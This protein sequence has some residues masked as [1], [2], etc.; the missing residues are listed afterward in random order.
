MSAISIL[1]SGPQPKEGASSPVDTSA[2]STLRLD[3]KVL[4][5]LG[6]DPWL[7]YWIETRAGT[8]SPWRTLHYGAFD[9]ALGTWTGDFTQRVIVTPDNETRI[10][11]SGDTRFVFPATPFTIS[12]AGDGKPDAA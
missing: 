9:H 7:R 11:W 1:T 12:C 5:D 8:T 3:V 4:A 10:R 6:L 2:F